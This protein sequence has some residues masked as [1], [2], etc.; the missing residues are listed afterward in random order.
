MKKEIKNIFQDSFDS[1]DTSV[2]TQTLLAGIAAK[3]KPERK[4]R[5][6]WWIFPMGLL[7]IVGAV[8]LYN[9]AGDNNTTAMSSV[10]N[11][12][13]ETLVV[14]IE[15]NSQFDSN[16]GTISTSDF[17][18]GTIENEIVTT[19]QI[20][21]PQNNLS[22]PSASHSQDNYVISKPSQE[23]KVSDTHS[24]GRIAQTQEV[25]GQQKTATVTSEIA[26]TVTTT[27]TKPIGNSI[28]ANKEPQKI[29]AKTLQ[30][31]KDKREIKNESV[32]ESHQKT[33]VVKA[34]EPAAVKEESQVIAQPIKED[35]Q[36]VD[37]EKKVELSVKDQV[38]EADK[39][40]QKRSGRKPMMLKVF[41][42]ANRS[43]SSF[44]DSSIGPQR[45]AALTSGTGYS[46]GLQFSYNILGNL[47][48]GVGL[49]YTRSFQ[50]FEWSGQYVV[51]AN[52]DYVGK[53]LPNSFESSEFLF[54]E[55]ERNI[56]KDNIRSFLDLPIS[57]SYGMSY[58]KFAVEPG[59]FV[60]FKL[61][62]WQKGYSVDNNGIP[63]DL[64]SYTYNVGPRMGASLGLSY[65]ISDNLK[66]LGRMAV[67][68]RIIND[69]I[70]EEV[71]SLPELN[72]GMGYRF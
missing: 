65:T 51:D 55:K 58:G 21:P 28:P 64:G 18:E 57:L 30:T 63:Q 72:L 46:G 67:S 8:Y 44:D 66:L 32:P 40:K 31:N 29:V 61:A 12:E 37:S 20:T 71:L 17:S 1:Y 56:Y 35:N 11:S 36:L 60:A 15:N 68:R 69:G 2:D 53:D 50:L 39:E 19:P 4:K 49:D 47:S 26:S 42:G 6:F 22:H 14:S 9:I 38:S 23:V 70:V 62:E 13:S 25:V 54:F 7:I 43:I 52:D 3:R 27:T 48:V 16:S 41:K 59:L 5:F 24:I 34:Q 33:A 45:S 10:S